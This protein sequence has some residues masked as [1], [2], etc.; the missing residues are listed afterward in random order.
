MMLVP[1]LARGSTIGF[2]EIARDAKG[3]SFTPGEASLAQSI[4]GYVA[5]AI[6]NAHLYAQARDMAVTEERGRLA[7]ELHD[8]VTQN[9]Y[10]VATISRTLPRLWETHPEEIRPALD[11]MQRLTTGA[12][13]EMRTLLLELRPAALLE[14]R[15]GELLEQLADAVKGRTRFDITTTVSGDRTFP[16]EVQFGLYR[17]AQEAL[18][19]VVKH[20]DASHVIVGLYCKGDRAVLRVSDNGTGFDPER[21]PPGRL[22]ITAMHERAA[23]IKADLNVTSRPDV[24]TEVKVIWEGRDRA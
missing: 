5:A 21:V 18:N 13:A 11:D 12:L 9:L 20:T 8:S 7:H 4:A 23:V 3:S 10:T 19:N 24:G 2:M 15:L 14:T 1:L 17:I 22:G 16:P 6:D